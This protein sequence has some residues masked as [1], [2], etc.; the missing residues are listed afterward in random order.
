M[1]F[2]LFVIVILLLSVFESSSQ[3]LGCNLTLS[4][5]NLIVSAMK[6][7]DF[8]QV[9]DDQSK[10]T[11]TNPSSLQARYGKCTETLNRVLNQQGLSDNCTQFFEGILFNGAGQTSGDISS[12]AS[13]ICTQSSFSSTISN[14]FCDADFYLHL[15]G[16]HMGR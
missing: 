14:F 9:L 10:C 12:T 5:F 3:S 13:T 2:V 8:Y 11:S 7:R 6:Q 1:P 16:D 15:I 4:D